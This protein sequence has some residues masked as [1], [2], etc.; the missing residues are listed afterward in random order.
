LPNHLVRP[1]AP[2]QSLE[3]AICSSAPQAKIAFGPPEIMVDLAEQYAARS[4]HRVRLHLF[5]DVAWHPELRSRVADR[6]SLADHVVV[7]DPAQA[8]SYER[9]RPTRSGIGGEVTN[10]WLRWILDSTSGGR[11]D[12]I[13]FATHGFLSGDRG[14]IAVASTPNL[15]TDRQMSRFIGSVEITAFLTRL[16]AWG[17]ALSGP[18]GNVSPA[19]LRE[20]AD[21]VALVLP[22][23]ALVHDLDHDPHA[24]QL[25][26]AL[27]TILGQ[28]PDLDRP[29]PAV[30]AW[31]HP[32]F[33]E[34]P[35]EDQ[36]ELHLNVDGSSSFIADATRS[37]LASPGTEAWVASLSRCVEQLQVRWLPDTPDEA[38]DPAAV[39]ALNRVSEMLERHVARE[40]PTGG[41]SRGD[42]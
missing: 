15:D 31:V 3:V 40:Y 14:A 18:P 5:T 1:Q 25:G 41:T 28:G 38:A 24:D 10:P 26:L 12:V 37:A 19:G 4:G 6:A 21:A 22:G 7:H 39:E 33:V 29:L 20:V 32:R 42:S 23:M 35:E 11:I 27:H 13:H 34:F 9:T 8:P 36:T 30:T 17:L 16:G 2:G